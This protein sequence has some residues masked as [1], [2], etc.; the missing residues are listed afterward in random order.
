MMLV[1][2]IPQARSHDMGVN[3]GGRNIGMAEHGLYA[4]Q[5]RAT[6]QQVGREAVS[7]NMGRKMVKDTRFLAMAL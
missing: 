4:S 7:E 6:F 5:V 2:G 3:L 1:D